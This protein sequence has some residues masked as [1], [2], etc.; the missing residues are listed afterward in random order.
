VYGGGLT[1]SF[2]DEIVG[3]EHDITDNYKKLWTC[4][5]KEEK[6]NILKEIKNLAELKKTYLE[7]FAELQKN[8]IDGKMEAL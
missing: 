8:I 6:D 4:K 2:C 1:M 7:S 5:N 3:I